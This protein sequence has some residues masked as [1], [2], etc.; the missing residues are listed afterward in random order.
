MFDFRRSYDCNSL[1]ISNV[2]ETVT[3]SGWVHR[4]R[5]HGGLIFIDL[6]DRYG[7][8]QL[9]FDPN[10]SK[11]E[12][13]KASSIRNEWVIS[14]LG[15]V[16]PRSEGM[17]NT[18]LTTGEI[19]IEVES[20]EIL[21]KAQ[22]PPFSICDEQIETNEEL[23]LK[24]RYLDIRRGNILKNL[25]LRN[26]AMLTTRKFF[27][28]KNFLEITTPILCK[29]TPE[30]ARDYLV[31]SRVYTGNFYALPQSP[32]I[33]KQILMI[34]GVDKYFQIATCFRDEDLRADRQ[35]EFTQIDVE[36]SFNTS[37]E[38]YAIIEQLMKKIFIE[39]LNIDILTPFHRLSHKEALERY[40]TD[41]PDLRFDMPL[42]R[43]SDIAEKSNFTIFREKIEKG[44]I[45]KAI[46]I[47]QNAAIS[48]KKI[49]E[50]ILFVKKFGLEGLAWMKKTDTGFSS[51]IV[52]FFSQSLLVE[53]ETRLKA[54]EGDI[55]F[56]AAG[57]ESTVNQAL[58]HLRRHIAKQ[59]K[60]I[61]P[62]TYKF[63]WVTD[64]PLFSQDPE[65]GQIKS[66]HHPFTS[67]CFEDI[68]LLEKTP[69]EAR[70]L[71]YDLVLNGYE[72]ASGSQRIH[73][74]DLQKKIFET[75][76][77]SEK[78]ILCKFGYFI[79]ALKYGVPPHIGIAIGFD[80]LIM[81]LVGTE[82]IRDVIAFPKTQKASDLMIQAPSKVDTNQL[83]E[84]KLTPEEE[85]TPWL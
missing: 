57:K 44:E 73:N 33:F 66:D 85:T 59:H 16:E 41:K 62:N 40:G 74:S 80:R 4:R 28:T 45:I 50:H 21:S 37:E 46:C 75:L 52:K 58:D 1:N 48:R 22:T 17:A 36:I 35:P 25:I 30:G 81:I 23:R 9:V 24:Y 31:P 68:P 76:N 63:L 39:S 84:L 10:V 60:L 26:K 12:H 14:I 38:I 79:E 47:K 61:P 64:F 51:S 20:L 5:D 43:V 77:L 32:Q 42:V 78:E 55:I 29:S 49:D 54:Q 15:K 8:T 83:D 82:N 18:N 2:G 70:A 65:T 3:L 13:E 6:R 11:Q 34:S 7:L 19:E 67:P 53:L 56:F 71:A 69:L 27:E 72:L